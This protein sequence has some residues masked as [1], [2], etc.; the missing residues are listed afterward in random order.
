MNNH[1]IPQ[2]YLRGFCKDDKLFCYVKHE[3]KCFQTNP[4]NV[5]SENKLY[6]DELEK[7]LQQR[8]ENPCDNIFDKI[9][10]RE[11]LTEEDKIAFA[12]YLVIIKIRI[13]KQK[14]EV[15]KY[16]DQNLE[17]SIIKI[18]QILNHHEKNNPALKDNI[19]RRRHEIAELRKGG[20]KKEEVWFSMI[21]SAQFPLI[22]NTMQKMHWY[23]FYATSDVFVTSDNPYYFTSSIGLGNNQG[24][25]L[26]PINSRVVLW[27]NWYLL[28]SEYNEA[29]KQFIIEANKRICHQAKRFIYFSTKEIW[30]EKMTNEKQL[31]FNKVEMKSLLNKD[32]FLVR[33]NEAEMKNYLATAKRFL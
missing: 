28:K 23:Y 2:K 12:N 5:G 3:N 18:E 1:Y 17:S 13:P 14:E 27:I 24:E 16:V 32:P 9:A 15:G 33:R 7:H 30:L 29:S 20:I 31:N 4:R 19:I 10:N 22:F 6:S 11:S 25:I 8:Y 21:E 26:F